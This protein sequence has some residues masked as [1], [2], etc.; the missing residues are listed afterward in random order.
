MFN[1]FEGTTS[2]QRKHFWFSWSIAWCLL[3][4]LN[5]LF[6]CLKNMLHSSHLYFLILVSSECL[7]LIWTDKFFTSWLQIE[8]DLGWSLWIC[9]LSF[10]KSSK[11]S[12]HFGHLFVEWTLLKCQANLIKVLKTLVLHSKHCKVEKS[13]LGSS[14]SSSSSNQSSSSN[15]VSFPFWR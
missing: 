15:S 8:Q 14:S 11:V 9:P 5:T 10:W 1:N 4:W 13:V 7:V 12:L 3:L 6:V 2:A